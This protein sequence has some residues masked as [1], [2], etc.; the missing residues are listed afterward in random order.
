[1]LGQDQK[2]LT[3]KQEVKE[4]EDVNTNHHKFIKN[5]KSYNNIKINHSC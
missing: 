5:F 4:E 1:M 3:E 2:G